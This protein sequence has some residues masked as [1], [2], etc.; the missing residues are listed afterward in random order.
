LKQTLGT[1]RPG[2]VMIAEITMT[3]RPPLAGLQRLFG[4][5]LGCYNRSLTDRLRHK[6]QWKWTLYGMNAVVFL[7]ATMPW[8][9]VKRG[10]A[11][12]AIRFQRF[13]R[14]KPAGPVPLSPKNL[15]ERDA[16]CDRMRLLNKR[17]LA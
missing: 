2:Y 11:Q 1:G 5:S 9:M 8:L 16:L 12:L 3:D 10:R 17:G 15:R 13:M 6:P 4:G 14:T 7:K